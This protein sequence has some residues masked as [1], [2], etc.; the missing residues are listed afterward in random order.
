MRVASPRK[1][2]GKKKNPGESKV[3]KIKEKLS[4][5]KETAK[6]KFEDCKEKAS[7][8]VDEVKEKT[9]EMLKTVQGETEEETEEE[10]DC[11]M[12]L[13]FALLGMCGS[14]YLAH[15]GD[16]PASVLLGG[17]GSF[18]RLFSSDRS[19]TDFPG[20]SFFFACASV[21]SKSKKKK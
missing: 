11:R 10:T 16:V 6:E 13:T 5:V 19:G 9:S 3:D 17:E 18:L 1:M 21:N 7:E 20:L 12:L 4:E 15:K 2:A 14:G 8:V